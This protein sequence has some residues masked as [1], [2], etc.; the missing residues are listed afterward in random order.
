MGWESVD[1]VRF[2]LE[3][4][5]QG[6]TNITKLKSAYNSLIIGSRWFGM[7]N[8]PIGNHGLGIFWCGQI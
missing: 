4:L 3:P 7:V 5:F 2:D 8:H 6:Q 1:V